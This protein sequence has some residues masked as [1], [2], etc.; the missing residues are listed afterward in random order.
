MTMRIRITELE[1]GPLARRLDLSQSWMESELDGVMSRDGRASGTADLSL[2]VSGTTVTVT[3]RVEAD[4]DVPCSRCL[5][6]ARVH[7][8]GPYR[9]VLAKGP[10]PRVEEEERELGPEDLELA[11]YDGDHFDLAPHIR[12]HL[13]LS[14][15][16]AP[17]C[18]ADC[19]P[20]W[21][22]DAVVEQD[23]PVTGAE[24]GE[25]EEKDRIDPRW[26]PLAALA[27]KLS[28]G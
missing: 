16:I 11:Y 14:V 22:G 9:L 5:G 17:L 26:A 18:R 7:V 15:P 1:S 6:P 24:Q 10:E 20:E 21:F 8:S 13:L 12:E 4:F 28:R 23:G 27:A 25:F 2:S 19:W 3:G